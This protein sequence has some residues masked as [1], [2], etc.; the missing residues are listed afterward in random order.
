MLPLRYAAHWRVASIVLLLLVI[1]ATLSP[2]VWFFDSKAKALLWF[3][4]AD[5]WLHG[6]TFA[7]L[8]L[9]FTGLYG[10]RSWFFVALGLMAVGFVVEGCQLLVSYR[11]AD[12]LDIAANTAGIVFGFVAAATVTGGWG[13]RFEDWLLERREI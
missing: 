1:A 4:N 5:K 2:A 10:R 8:T 12:W 11:T 9:W 13:T 3:H 7:I 6:M